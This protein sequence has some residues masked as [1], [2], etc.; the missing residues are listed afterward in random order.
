MRLFANPHIMSLSQLVL[1]AAALAL[2]G[3]AGE[4][5]AQEGPPG[6]TRPVVL[7][8]FDPH[9]SACAAPTGLTNLLAFAQDNE[10]KFMQ[11]VAQGLALAAKD[12]GLEY[13]VSH[14]NND[15]ALMI[16]QVQHI[17]SAKVGA[18]VAA[19]IDAPSL[20]PDP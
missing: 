12:R 14:A 13:Q 20:I 4:T 16:E 10:R 2:A 7:P 18:L 6:I 5:A 15:P 8:P 9:A 11:G 3:S 19:P 1:L 17:L